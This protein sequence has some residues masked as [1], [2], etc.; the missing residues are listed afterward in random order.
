MRPKKAKALIV[1]A[2]CGGWLAM[3]GWLDRATGYE[4]GLFAFYTAPVAVVA[5]NQGQV[6]GIIVAL[7]ASVVWFMA[8][9]YAGD[10]YSAPFYGYWNKCHAFRNLHHQCHHLWQNKNSARA[11]GVKAHRHE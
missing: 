10:H 11:S 7:V 9:R 2:G 5:W 8:D 1:F 3:L 4:L 6:P